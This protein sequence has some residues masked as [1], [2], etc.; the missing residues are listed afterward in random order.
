MADVETHAATEKTTE[1]NPGHAAF[2][3]D[4]GKLTMGSMDD[5][6]D[7]YARIMNNEERVLKAV[8]RAVNTARE[9]VVED[10]LFTRLTLHEIALNTMRRLTVI[11][12]DLLAVRRVKD[13]APALTKGDRKIYVG[14]ILILLAFVVFFVFSI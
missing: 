5:R 9:R 12:Q 1:T 13:I 7:A 10:Q 14:I 2:L 6:G 11:M 8:D 3:D 4:I